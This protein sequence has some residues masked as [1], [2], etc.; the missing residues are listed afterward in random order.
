MGICLFKNT[1]TSL[2]KISAIKTNIALV[3]SK[4]YVPLTDRIEATPLKNVARR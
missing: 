3:I 1:Q 2:Y 4:R